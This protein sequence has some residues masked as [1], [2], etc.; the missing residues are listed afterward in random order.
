M[1]ATVLVVV[2]V[3]GSAFVVSRRSMRSEGEHPPPQQDRPRP[4]RCLGLDAAQSCRVRYMT[5]SD[6]RPL[7]SPRT[8]RVL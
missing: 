1:T 8:V 4:F 5:R 3:K 7:R 2:I 6:D